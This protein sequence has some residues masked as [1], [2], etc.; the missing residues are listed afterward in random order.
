MCLALREVLTMFRYE[1]LYALAIPVISA[2]IVA[3]ILAAVGAP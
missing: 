1:F 3:A 2:G